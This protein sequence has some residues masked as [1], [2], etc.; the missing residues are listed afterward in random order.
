MSTAENTQQ[1]LLLWP[2][3]ARY[4]IPGVNDSWNDYQKFCKGKAVTGTEWKEARQAL[5][6]QYQTYLEEG[7]QPAHFNVET[8]RLDHN[9]N[10]KM[11]LYDMKWFSGG[12][13]L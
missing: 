12:V 7:G 3:H 1:G 9:L 5:H 10:S 4:L 8:H 6:E 2:E 13:R 11:Y